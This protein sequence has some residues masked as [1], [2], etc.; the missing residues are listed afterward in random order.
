MRV[1]FE[2]FGSLTSFFG[3]KVCVFSHFSLKRQD[4]YATNFFQGLGENT[5]LLQPGLKSTAPGQ[6]TLDHTNRK[7]KFRIGKNETLIAVDSY[8]LQNVTN[9]FLNYVECRGSI[10]FRYCLVNYTRDLQ[11]AGEN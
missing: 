6:R 5:C 2:A 9:T 4:G 8:L 3:I 11:T 10:F 1:A 7:T